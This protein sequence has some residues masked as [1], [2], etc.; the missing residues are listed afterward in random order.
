MNATENPTL[1]GGQRLAGCYTLKHP[2]SDN[3]DHTVWLAQDEVLG[4]EVTLHFVPTTLLRDQRAVA[5]LRQE[6]KRNR[7]LIHPNILRVYDYVEDATS[8]AVSMDK[9]DG[10][11][12]AEILKEKGALD[13]QEIQPWVAQLAETLSDAHRIQLIHRDLA[14]D[15]LILR[16]NGNILV[17][18]FGIARSMRDA[19]ERANI[20]KG[21]TAHL[22]YMSPQQIDGDRPVPADDVYGLGALIFELLTGRPPFVGGELVPQIRKA[23]PP[24]I[25]TLRAEHGKSAVP[26]SWQNVVE[27]CLAKTSEQRPRTCGE[28]ASMIAGGRGSALASTSPAAPSAPARVEV[29]ESAAPS[30][31]APQ[32]P[33]A[34]TPVES[35]PSKDSPATSSVKSTLPPMPPATA[36]IKKLAPAV[37]ANYPDLERPGSK[38]MALVVAVAAVI[39]GAGVV[40]KVSND[41]ERDLDAKSGAGS[42]GSPDNNST[43]VAVGAPSTGDTGSKA[44]DGNAGS[45]TVADAN[46]G[47]STNPG[48]PGGDSTGGNPP[49]TG[50]AGTHSA[51]PGPVVKQPT[52]RPG[53]PGLIGEPE[54]SPTADSGKPP[55]EAAKPPAETPK[56][57]NVAQ[58]KPADA[59]KN[60]EKVPDK[61]TPA[62]APVVPATVPA[63][64][65]VPALPE[66]PPAPPKLVI[67]SN[68]T[69]AQLEALMA[70]RQAA[71]DKVAEAEKAADTAGKVTAKLRDV[72]Q[73]EIEQS[74]KDFE[75]KKKGLAQIIQQASDVQKESARMEERLKSAKAAREEAI[76]AADLAEKA[77]NEFNAQSAE[78]VSASKKAE[79]DLANLVMQDK[80]S[81]AP[82]DDLN[83][84]VS[85]AAALRQQAASALR[86][87]E[88][89]KSSIASQL[90]KARAAEAE[91]MRKANRE[92]I[93]GIEA[94]MKPLEAEATKIKS[95]LAQLKDLGAAGEGA[96]KQIQARLDEVNAKISAKQDEIKALNGGALPT[97]TGTTP[98][99]RDKT[100]KGEA[101]VPKTISTEAP[102]APVA[103]VGNTPPTAATEALRT[104]ALP[105]GSERTTLTI[106]VPPPSAPAVPSAPVESHSPASA[107]SNTPP[108]P[109]SN[110][111]ASPATTDSD[112]GGANSIG[113]KFAPVGNVQFAIYPVTVQQFEVFAKATNLTSTAWQNA[114]QPG[115][116]H[117]GP[118][119]PV[120]NVTWREADAFC[121]WLTDR[122][123]KSG[124]LKAG[125]IYRLPSDLEWSK[126][127][128]LPDEAGATPEDRDMSI[129]NV[130]PWGSQWPPPAG[131]GNYCGQETGSQNPIQGYTDG[132][133]FTSPVGKFKP[134][135]TGLYD[136]SGN[137][138]QWVQDDWN[139]EHTQKTLRGSSW[140]SGDIQLGL[141][142]SCRFH[143]S[144]TLGSET[145]G[146][147][148]VKAPD[149]KGGKH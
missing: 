42:P 55:T 77:L 105:S 33:P 30:R 101:I 8:A 45:N 88:A 63:T 98:N 125:E 84:Q 71:A 147:R 142:S 89:D 85:K 102:A 90:A 135:A 46:H 48:N 66:L 22:S 7:Q 39:L 92:K 126:A 70:E 64:A 72:K 104:P 44:T 148:I 40:M 112:S 87:L 37:P 124:A 15:N 127:I 94:E 3:P 91:A 93:A 26:D 61:A 143:S 13:P 76:K 137:V 24:S 75:K 115:A 145:N 12:L 14:P 129:P 23:Q 121:K 106:N 131:S 65:D 74:G 139:K 18:S 25:N 123:H 1:T 29:R 28:V 5:E 78:K 120:V 97:P 132:Y 53:R 103:T 51:E 111:A 107:A 100:K 117:Q 68:A 140:Q 2:L 83:A 136:M 82:L 95:A 113:A 86:Q 80:L 96:S 146:F 43:P 114:F 11:T 50:S 9:Y 73:A 27:A 141:L 134:T 67:P 119:H 128:G 17:T 99:K 130:Y 36:A 32:E 56:P 47:T 109:A 122:E 41:T 10:R 4:K 57:T 79:N 49:E 62:P 20:A 16:S 118:D 133:E 149:T 31:S 138:F 69:A 59:Q 21:E 110:P 6:V 58:A 19:M 108:A 144:P 81:A 35:T 60:P 116:F 38:K 54:K 52:P 34:K